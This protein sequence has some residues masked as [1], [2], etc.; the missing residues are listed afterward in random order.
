M[1]NTKAPYNV[2]LPTASIALSALSIQGVA[3]MSRAVATLNDN[4]TALISGLKET[5]GVGRILG[6]C[7]AN[8]VLAEVLD[9]EGKPSNPKAVEV[10]KA[11]AESKGVVVRFRGTEPGC[12][13]CLRITVGT[14]S[15]C[16]EAVE[17]LRGLLA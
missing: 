14:V 10:Y 13:G 7:H 8:F 15:E 16:K 3:V 9:G 6:E 11:M 17:Q 1:T 12:E 4:R 2:S 5:K